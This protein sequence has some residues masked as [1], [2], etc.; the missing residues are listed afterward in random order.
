[1]STLEQVVAQLQLEVFTLKVLVADQ[2]G[3]A[4]VVRV[5]KRQSSKNTSCHQGSSFS[6]VPPLMPAASLVLFAARDLSEESSSLRECCEH[7]FA[8]E[9]AADCCK[10]SD[11]G[12]SYNGLE[13]T[14]FSG[15]EC[16]SWMKF[17]RRTDTATYS[18][19]TQPWCFPLHDVSTP[20]VCGVSLRAAA[21]RNL[22]DEA[23]DLTLKV[24]APDC[25]YTDQLHGSTLTTRDTS[26][27]SLTQLSG[28]NWPQTAASGGPECRGCPRDRD[29]WTS[30]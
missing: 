26:V 24:K 11:L 1:M 20:T 29:D 25:N 30:H 22:G 21:E 3:R 2:T 5:I 7:S 17:C 14:K 8:A 6:F 23:H 15:L 27:T 4:E 9:N 28:K 13:H 19:M 18:S 16:A 10:E 12:E